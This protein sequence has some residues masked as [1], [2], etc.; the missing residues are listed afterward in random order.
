[1]FVCDPY[2]LALP[3]G[4]PA[5]LPGDRHH[6]LCAARGQGGDG[7][8]DRPGR[9]GLPGPLQPDGVCRA[10][11]ARVLSEQLTDPAQELARHVVRAVLLRVS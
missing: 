7:E 6:G 3:G 10:A 9:G 2:G 8:G 5:L 1:M 4:Q 11:R